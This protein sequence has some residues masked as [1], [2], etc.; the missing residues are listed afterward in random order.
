MA[1]SVEGVAQRIA[2]LTPDHAGQLVGEFTTDT[3][4]AVADVQTLLGSAVARVSA[5]FG[6]ADTDLADARD[7]AAM[8]IAA[9]GLALSYDPTNLD[10]I[11]ALRTHAQDVITDLA[12][13][14]ARLHPGT[15]ED[16]T[17]EQPI[18][19]YVGTPGTPVWSMP[20]APGTCLLPA[21]AQRPLGWPGV[22]VPPVF[23]GRV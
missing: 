13:G 4:P 14:Y 3:I 6:T 22:F 16:G 8:W 18:D 19:G 21:L 9:A 23:D 7:D 20:P 11:Q 12:A 5:R 2:R 10:M 17:S 15:G 1:V